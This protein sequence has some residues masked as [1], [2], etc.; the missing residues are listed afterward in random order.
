MKVF[1][2]P[3][4]PSETIELPETEKFQNV[5]RSLSGFYGWNVKK[6][7]EDA[8]ET[9][10]ELLLLLSRKVASI[11]GRT[12]DH[13][14]SV[15][16]VRGKF[17]E[18]PVNSCSVIIIGRTRITEALARHFSLLNFN[19]TAIGPN[20]K[21]EDYPSSVKCHCLDDSYDSVQFHK[22]DIVIVA[23]H[24]SQD[25]EFV[26]RALEAKCA[27]VGMIGSYKRTEEVLNYLGLMD[28]EINSPLY[29]PAGM[30]IDARNP[31]E[32][33]LSIVV[34]ILTLRARNI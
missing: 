31:D 25:P 20:L 11:R 5:I 28:M 6:N 10:E 34:E 29:I 32:I 26:R 4:V 2:D 14:R 7:S 17:H 19:I 22:N 24:T 1:I 12:H 21:N 8:P 30:D 23:S 13:L 16:E 9:I 3:V 18:T 15:K 27:Y 33:A